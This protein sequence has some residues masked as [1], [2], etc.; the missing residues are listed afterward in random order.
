[1]AKP[2]KHGDGWRI[3]WFDERG[4]RQS[5]TFIIYKDAEFALKKYETEVEEIRKGVRLPK[6]PDK[7]FSELADEYLRL[8]SSRKKNPEDDQSIIRA[9]LR[10]Y[11]GD[12]LITHIGTSVDEFAL[13]RTH[14]SKKTVHN[15]LTL[16][17]SMLNFAHDQK[18]IYSVPRIKKPKIKIFDS[19]YRYLRTS[20]EIRRFLNAAK[21]ISELAYYTYAF[22]IYTGMR[23]GEIAALRWT[24]IDLSAR[25]ITVQRGFHSTTKSDEIRHV[26][27][28]D[29]L[30]PLMLEWRNKNSGGEM[31]FPNREGHMHHES[32]P[33][34]R[35]TL[36]KALVLGEFPKVHYKGK[37]CRYV[38]FHGL[39]HTFASHWM[40]NGGDIFRLSKI[41]GHSDIK[42]TMRYA[43]LEPNV[44]SG[45][46]GRFGSAAP[47]SEK[48]VVLK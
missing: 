24:D 45:D 34:F 43:H 3:R 36:H 42:V 9:H 18:W 7:K 29:A 22:A 39:R 4:V 16:L 35:E 10:P 40:M 17:I 14:L 6:L 26:P 20:E 15:I 27:I 44:F 23:V 46:Y 11:F 41:L 33:I 13:T 19:E 25:R 5:E 48:L 2:V 21:S 37:L 31:V 12:M 32:A 30:L 1:M 38:P 28:V 8:R 47:A